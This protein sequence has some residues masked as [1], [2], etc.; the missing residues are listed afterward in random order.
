MAAS[1]KGV[2]LY[3]LVPRV[4]GQVDGRSFG[5]LI[6]RRSEGKIVESVESRASTNESVSSVERQYLLPN[7]QVGH[8]GVLP[9]GVT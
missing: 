9:E 3:L 4:A 1:D 5:G 8:G 2:G 6:G 7:A